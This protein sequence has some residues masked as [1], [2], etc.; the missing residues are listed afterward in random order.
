MG[1]SLKGSL[2]GSDNAGA[3]DLQKDLQ[4]ISFRDKL[5]NTCAAVF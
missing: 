2:R 3:E 1:M 5:D 4:I